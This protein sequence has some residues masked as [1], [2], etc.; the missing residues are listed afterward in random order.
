MLRLSGISG[1]MSKSTISAGQAFLT[2]SKHTTGIIKDD[3]KV[4]HHNHDPFDIG[5]PAHC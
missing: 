4:L 3:L 5:T 1:K 2:E